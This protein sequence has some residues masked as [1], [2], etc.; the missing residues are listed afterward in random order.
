K[1]VL[2]FAAAALA[3]AVVTAASARPE[4]TAS[5]AKSARISCHAPF[6]VGFVSPI[7]GGAGF[8][9]TEQLSWAK[10]AMKT[11]APALGFK[12]TLVVGDTPVEQGPAP[13]QTAAQRFIADTKV[14]GV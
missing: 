5:S 12:A 8:L 7:T 3:L 9:G 11:I 4:K 1:F 6:K 2:P 10:Y 14:L 13:A